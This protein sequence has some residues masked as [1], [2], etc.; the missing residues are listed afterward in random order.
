M[1]LPASIDALEARLVSRLSEAARTWLAA[2]RAETGRDGSALGRHFSTAARKTG[3]AVLL[4]SPSAEGVRLFP[5][6]PVLD[7]WRVD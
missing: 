2:A 3:H 7:P 6:G 1:N 4:A 5:G